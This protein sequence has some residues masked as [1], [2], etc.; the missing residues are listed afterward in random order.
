MNEAIIKKKMNITVT[1]NSETEDL[2][3]ITSDEEVEIM[4]QVEKA[5]NSIPPVLNNGPFQITFESEWK[6][7]SF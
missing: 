4:A 2:S 3:K 6:G 1:V 5:I 7:E